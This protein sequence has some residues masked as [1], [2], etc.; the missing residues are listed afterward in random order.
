L[1]GGNGPDGGSFAFFI[2]ALWEEGDFA[3]KDQMRVAAVVGVL[4]EGLVSIW[5]Y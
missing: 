5:W 2:L 1:V 3:G 4:A